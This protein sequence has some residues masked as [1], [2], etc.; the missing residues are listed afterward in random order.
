MNRSEQIQFLIGVIIMVGFPLPLLFIGQ[1]YILFVITVLG[2][3]I[4]TGVLVGKLCPKCLNF[5]CPFN[6]VPKDVVDAFLRRNLV[7]RRAWEAKGY[8]LDSPDR[9]RRE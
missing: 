8:E 3:G 4:W 1:R 5:S 2:I 9:V 6:R 7:M